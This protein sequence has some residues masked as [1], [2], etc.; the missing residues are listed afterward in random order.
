M[1]ERKQRSNIAWH[2]GNFMLL[3]Q[4]DT[5]CKGDCGETR[6]GMFLSP[7]CQISIFMSPI[8]DSREVW[9]NRM[10]LRDRITELASLDAIDFGLSLI[11]LGGDG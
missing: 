4:L 8:T 6:G 7:F 2:T 1:N 5:G 11:F 3:G 9:E 10:D